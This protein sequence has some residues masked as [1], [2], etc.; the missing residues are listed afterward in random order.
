MEVILHKFVRLPLKHGEKL[1]LMFDFNGKP[2]I[3]RLRGNERPDLQVIKGD[4]LNRK[5]KVN[6]EMHSIE[7]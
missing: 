3:R 7:G 5:V 2:V 4:I 1:H 6:W